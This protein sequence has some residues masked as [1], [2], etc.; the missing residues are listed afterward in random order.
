[1][2]SKVPVSGI[3]RKDK[4]GG[5]EEYTESE[6]PGALRS[7]RDQCSGGSCAFDSDGA[8]EDKYLGLYWKSEREVG[9][10]DIQC[11]PGFAPEALLGK[12]LVDTGILCG[13][14]GAG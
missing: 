1:M 9:V 14:G 11:V 6:Y 12:P 5:G 13:N 10:T 8:T 2:V 7:S 4:R 3:E